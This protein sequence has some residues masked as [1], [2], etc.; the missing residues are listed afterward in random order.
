MSSPT[1]SVTI[2][3]YFKVRPG[4]LPAAKAL[5]GDFI[6]RTRTEPGVLQYEFTICDD[7][8]FC[9]E[10]YRDA[11]ALLA[12]IGNVGAQVQQMLGLAELARLE[13][14]GPAA[15]L[16]KLKGPLAGMNPAWYAYECGLAR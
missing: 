16:A 6:A 1:P 11:E 12:H 5:L 10:A 2:H 13:I 3:P 8:I 9:R 4:N 7:T 14:H 15:E